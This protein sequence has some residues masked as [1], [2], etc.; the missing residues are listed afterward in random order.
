MKN[1]LIY[2]RRY[3]TREDAIREITEYIEIFYNRQRLQKRLGYVP[4]VVYEQQFY[5]G[6][7]QLKYFLLVSTIDIRG[8]LFHRGQID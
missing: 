2:H 4:P 8:H 7:T 6:G 1:E 3:A 5:A